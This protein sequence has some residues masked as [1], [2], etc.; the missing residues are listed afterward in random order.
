[1]FI[2]TTGVSGFVGAVAARVLHG[3]G[4]RVRALVRDR[5]RV[6]EAVSPLLAEVVEGDLSNREAL[7]RACDGVD[8][9]L[10]L[11]GLTK[12]ARDA[13]F[14]KTNIEGTRI[15]SE[16]ARDAGVGRFLLVSSLAAAGASK[17]GVPRVES[18]LLQPV[19][20]YGRSKLGGE[21]A[22]AAIFKNTSVKFTIVRP[23]IVYGEGERDMLMVFQQIKRGFLP[24]VGG[25][26]TLQ[27]SYSL[28]HVDDLALG[29]VQ[30]FESARAAGNSYFLPGPRDATFLQIIEAIEG[31]LGRRAR[32][33]N[34]PMAAAR[35][36]AWLIQ[37]GARLSG[38][39]SIVNLDKL[40]EMEA[41]DWRCSGAAAARDFGYAPAIDF[42]R[43]FALEAN[44]ARA[45]GLL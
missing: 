16:A 14:V 7:R 43:G 19:S 17:P 8:G 6:A 34:L 45:K 26:K 28:V 10:H 31:T 39:P 32:K 22:A 1:M 33:L 4:H 29:M 41:G 12:A 36:V 40:R 11:A 5:R 30:C 3:R 21:E 9:V 37:T 23:P 13:E 15:L 20:A 38:R 35:P 42:D 44:W 18:D 25:S 24:I 2:L 27:L